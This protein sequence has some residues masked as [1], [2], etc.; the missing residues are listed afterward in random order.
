MLFQGSSI[1]SVDGALGFQERPKGMERSTI[2]C[3]TKASTFVLLMLLI[4]QVLPLR[5][6]ILGS[7]HNSLRVQ[8]GRQIQFN[9]RRRK[10]V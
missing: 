4:L 2:L 10:G 8:Y 7:R 1:K 3:L 5:P 6:P 9:P